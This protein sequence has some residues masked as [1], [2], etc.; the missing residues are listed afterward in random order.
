MIHAAYVPQP[1]LTLDLTLHITKQLGVPTGTP[2][3]YLIRPH[4]AAIV[5]F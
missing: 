5:R 2:N 1:N 4:L 3:S